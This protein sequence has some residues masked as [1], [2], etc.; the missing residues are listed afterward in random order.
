MRLLWDGRTDNWHQ[1]THLSKA[2][3]RAGL[4]PEAL[5]QAIKMDP[6]RYDAAIEQNQIAHTAA[7]HA[8]V[9]LFV[10]LG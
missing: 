2:I 3:S 6:E 5:R 9:P 10:F 1:G 7:G 4:N 8:G